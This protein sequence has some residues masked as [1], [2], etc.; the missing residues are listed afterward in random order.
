MQVRSVA[1]VKACGFGFL[2]EGLMN[3]TAMLLIQ[4]VK[5]TDVNSQMARHGTCLN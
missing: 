2:P 1:L 5:H 4:E 3:L